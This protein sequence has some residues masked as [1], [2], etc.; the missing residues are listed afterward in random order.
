MGALP[1]PSSFPLNRASTSRNNA[2]LKVRRPSQSTR[3][4]FGS[5]DSRRRRRVTAIAAAPIGTLIRKIDSQPS[6]SVSAPPTSG[7][8]ATATPIVAPN[9]AMARP[10]SRPAGNSCAIRA[11]ETANRIAAPTP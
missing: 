3:D 6:R 9:S 8:I 10:R 11:S 5:R 1:Q 7:P 2:P 4:A